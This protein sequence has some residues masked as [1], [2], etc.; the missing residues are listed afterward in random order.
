MDI[1]VP[2]LF[3]IAAAVVWLVLGGTLALLA[4]RVIHERDVH[5]RPVLAR[6]RTR[7]VAQR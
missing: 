2:A 4:G 5:D 3:G 7:V 6:R 1:V